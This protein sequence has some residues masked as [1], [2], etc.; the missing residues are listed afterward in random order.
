MIK[1]YILYGIPGAGK[2]VIAQMLKEKHNFFHLSM[3]EYLRTQCRL[4]NPRLEL[5]SKDIMEGLTLIDSSIV[6]NIYKNIF[7]DCLEKKKDLIIDGFPRTRE[8]LDFLKEITKKH[9]IIPVYFYLDIDPKLAIKR[10]ITRETCSIC[11]HDYIMKKSKINLI[12]DICEGKLYK[13]ETDNEFT[14][15]KRIKLFHNTTYKM[16][17]ILKNDIQIFDTNYDINTLPKKFISFTKFLVK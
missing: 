3:G 16:I 7:L 8:Q 1:T 14:I 11:S 13:R 15:K 4:K 9:K 2:G 10:L 6:C 5:Y 12:C 17:Q